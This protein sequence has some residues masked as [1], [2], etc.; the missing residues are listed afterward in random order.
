MSATTAE[1]G[2]HVPKEEGLRVIL[3]ILPVL[4][5]C[6]PS[7]PLLSDGGA[8]RPTVQ[9]VI[10]VLCNPMGLQ[11]AGPKIGLTR[12]GLHSVLYKSLGQSRSHNTTRPGRATS[13]FSPQSPHQPRLGFQANTKASIDRGANYLFTMDSKVDAGNVVMDENVGKPAAL[14]ET[15][16]VL[17]KAA[18]RRLCLKF[19]VRLMPVL[20]LMCKSGGP[21]PLAHDA[22]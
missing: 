2:Y 4:V 17:D 19:D 7:F 6:F 9:P 22:N 3:L 15:A 12:L 16:R 8:H 5:L 21:K 11:A 20:A 18:E 14:G 10:V 13:L 1:I